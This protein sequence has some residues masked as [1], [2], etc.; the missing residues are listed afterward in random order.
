MKKISFMKRVRIAIKKLG[1]KLKCFFNPDFSHFF[2]D[3]YLGASNR[4]SRNSKIL[5]QFNFQNYRYN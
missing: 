4:K 3:V 5:E 2:N 1:Y